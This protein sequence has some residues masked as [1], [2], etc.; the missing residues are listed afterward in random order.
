[1]DVDFVMNLNCFE[2]YSVKPFKF[3][4]SKTHTIERDLTTISFDTVGDLERIKLE[5][6]IQIILWESKLVENQ[7][8]PFVILRLKGLVKFKN[9]ACKYVINGVN[10]LYDITKGSQ[11]EDETAVNRIVVIGKNLDLA[12]IEK[13][14]IESLGCLRLV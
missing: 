4:T 10:D 14:F 5:K 12:A 3:D 13:S 6:W 1:V 7:L 8:V 11:W 2:G 9:D